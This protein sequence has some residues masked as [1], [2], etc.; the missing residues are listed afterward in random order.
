MKHLLFALSILS[1][2][3]SSCKKEETPEPEVKNTF[4]YDGTETLLGSGSI[5]DFGNETAD[6]SITYTN[7]NHDIELYTDGLTIVDA[8]NGE[9]SGI[10]NKI[11]LEFWSGSPKLATALYTFKAGAYDENLK[12]SSG[13]FAINYDGTKNEAEKWPAIVSG[14]VNVN[15]FGEDNYEI[16]VDCI[17]ETGK[18]ITAYY[19]G[20][21]NYIVVR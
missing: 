8:A 13:D 20:N 2:S 14:T 11:Y 10:G 12:I 3:L 15:N 17:D 16:T 21:L 19:N 4:I 7:Y 5:F 1:I 6:G 9:L 18:K